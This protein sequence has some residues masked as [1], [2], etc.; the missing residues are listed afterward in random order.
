MVER[1]WT[2]NQLS[3]IGIKEFIPILPKLALNFDLTTEGTEALRIHQGF[4]KECKFA[5]DLVSGVKL[6][7]LLSRLYCV[8]FVK[9]E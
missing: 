9:I 4:Q 6:L 8:I 3:A 7:L 5:P 2:L 1:I